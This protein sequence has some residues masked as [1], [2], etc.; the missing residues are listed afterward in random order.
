ME[1]TLYFPLLLQQAAVLVDH[2]LNLMEIQ[3]DQAAVLEQVLAE[4]R[5]LSAQEQLIKVLL[6]V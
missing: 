2:E 5:E 1:V 3:V 4:F 6:V